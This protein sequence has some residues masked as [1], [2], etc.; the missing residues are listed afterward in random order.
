MCRCITDNSSEA[1]VK[2]VNMLVCMC[3]CEEGGCIILV[4]IF[5]GITIEY[6]KIKKK[7]LK[8]QTLFL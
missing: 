1:A 4:F 2:N 7:P 3:V 5:L 8:I 6:Q